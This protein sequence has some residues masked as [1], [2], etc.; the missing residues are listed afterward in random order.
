MADHNI[1]PSMADPPA[2]GRS[3][4][5]AVVFKTYTWDAFVQRQAE[6]LQEATGS[7]D[8][9][10]SVDETNG[11]IPDIPFSNV[12]RFTCA[13]LIRSGLANRFDKGSLLWWNPD[14]AHYQFLAGHDDYDY[15]MFVEYDAVIRTPI[16][17]LIGQIARE[18]V[19]F[20]ALP[21]RTPIAEWFWTPSHRQV[22]DIKEMRGSLNCVTVFSH[23]ALC[24]MRARRVEMATDPKVRCWPIGEMFLPTEIERAGFSHRSLAEYGDVSAYD[25]FPPTLEE[26]LPLY[27]QATFMHPVLE[28]RRYVATMFKSKPFLIEF[29]LPWSKLHRRLARVPKREYLHLLPGEFYR[30]SL[31][32]I[33][34]RWRKVGPSL[35]RRMRPQGAIGPAISNSGD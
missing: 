21:M 27:T 34:T 25:W 5:F 33:A 3:V 31:V 14:Y 29:L 32:A 16:A 17:D 4:R 9:Y 28:P 8:F 2:T 19:D 22:Y 24:K 12:D 7:G 35:K 15:Y 23:R 10:I 1:N 11:A 13:D 6:R 30:R 20:V 18:Q 26:D